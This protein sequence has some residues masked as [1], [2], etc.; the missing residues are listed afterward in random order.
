MKNLFLS[1]VLLF[2]GVLCIQA[3]NLK[4][5]PKAGVNFTTVHGDLE[6]RKIKTGFHAGIMAEIG[7]TEVFAIQ[8]ELL[9]STQGVIQEG[10]FLDFDFKSTTKLDYLN[11]PIMGKYYI[12]ERFSIEL[13][14]QLGILLNS[15]S[16]YEMEG[17]SEEQDNKKMTNNMD[18]GLNAGLSYKL[19]NGIS[20]GARYNLGLSN[21]NDGENADDHKLRHGV[22]QVSVGY[23]FM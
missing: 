15:K 10:S 19:D 23:F 13:G 5:G 16:K 18:F 12:I 7:I 3:Q 14:P 1:T 21:I 22:I 20:F 6:D 9:Y 4:I 11:L 17:E 8:P 2:I